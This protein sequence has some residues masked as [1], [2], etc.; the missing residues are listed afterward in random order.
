[1]DVCVCKEML[2]IKLYM[3]RSDCTHAMR[4]A[5]PGN[6]NLSFDKPIIVCGLIGIRT[7]S[8]QT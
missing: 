4:S 8:L 1:M 3:F 6:I 7:L 2:F 5:P